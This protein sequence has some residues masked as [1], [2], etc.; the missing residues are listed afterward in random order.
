MGSVVY[1][2]TEA[3][4]QFVISQPLISCTIAGIILGNMVVGLTIGILL[5]L[6]YLVEF[7]IGGSKVSLGNMGAYIAAGLAVTFTQIFPLQSN[8]ILLISVLFGIMISRATIPFQRL[9]RQL[10]NK[11]LKCADNAADSGNLWKITYLH[12]LGV[13]F[14]YIFGAFFSAFIFIIGKY[15]CNLIIELVPSKMEQTLQ[16]LKP[17]LLGAG[18]G[19]LFWHFLKKNTIQYT[20]TGVFFGGILLLLKFV[21]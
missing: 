5:Q 4:G 13:L 20:L 11:L 3:V 7:P 19:A 17:V 15:I 8:I 12:Y 14:V 10:N 21:N 9:Q 1:A 6:P 16:I 2:D 18:T